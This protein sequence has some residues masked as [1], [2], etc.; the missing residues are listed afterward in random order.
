MTKFT[1]KKKS[2]K[3]NSPITFKEIGIALK[4]IHIKENS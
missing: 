1:Q 2:D 4:S 3:L